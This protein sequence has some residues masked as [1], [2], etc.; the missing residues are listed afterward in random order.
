MSYFN[1]ALPSPRQ[2]P[3]HILFNHNLSQL[4]PTVTA[5][6]RDENRCRVDELFSPVVDHL[7]CS[8]HQQLSRQQQLT[9]H[10]RAHCHH[11]RNGN[12]PAS[13]PHHRCSLLSREKRLSEPSPEASILSVHQLSAVPLH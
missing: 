10:R 3:S 12:I 8:P 2:R 6:N 13:F 9:G 5:K 1:A 4:P 11:L 7:I